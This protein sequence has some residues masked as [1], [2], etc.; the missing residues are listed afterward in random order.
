[1]PSELTATLEF[2]VGELVY[3]RS[4]LHCDGQRPRR[5]VIVERYVQQCHGGVQKLYRLHGVDG[6][7]VSEV[8][9]TRE[10]PEYRP[11]SE[12]YIEAQLAAE[13]RAEE[14]RDERW[15][16]RKGAMHAPDQD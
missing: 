7:L 14:A 1:M 4:A 2:E 6:N 12:G 11:L 13:A 5:F 8:A 15:N 16:R 3:P 10:E 9:L